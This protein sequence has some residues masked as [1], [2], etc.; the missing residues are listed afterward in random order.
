MEG[1]L[2]FKTD[3]VS[4]I[5]GSKFTVFALYYFVFRGNFLSTSPR[6]TYIWRGDLTEVFLRYRFGEGGYIWR[7]LYMV[8][9][10]FGILRYV[11]KKKTHTNKLK[12]N[13]KKRGKMKTNKQTKKKTAC[14]VLSLTIAPPHKVI[15]LVKLFLNSAFV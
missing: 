10:I 9:L 14:W 5:V 13:G 4:L 11:K 3:Q 15:N 7:G 2:R 6:G 1:N 12:Q 8:G